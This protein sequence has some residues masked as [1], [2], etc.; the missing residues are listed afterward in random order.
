MVL[1]PASK[2]SQGEERSIFQKP[3]KHSHHCHHKWTYKDYPECPKWHQTALRLM[4]IVL[5]ILV[6]TVIGLI[7]RVSHQNMHSFSDNHSEQIFSNENGTKYCN[8]MNT[9]P[10]KQLN[11]ANSAANLCP[12]DWLH[13]K[14][15]CYKFFMNF[16][17]WIDSQ[18]SCSL[19]KSHLLV[20][21]DK[22]ELE[23]IQS[24]IQVGNHF[25]IGLNITYPQKTWTWVDGTPLNLQ[26]FQ[27]TGQIKENAC[28][29]IT[30]KGVFSEKCL[31][32][33]FWI[34]Q[35]VISSSKAGNL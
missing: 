34:C 2:M 9:S 21:Q 10:R 31:M 28:A 1:S 32:E 22:A 6:T 26:L 8:C 12:D 30:N 14:G 24:N 16:K 18:N 20:I 15:K 3:R 11:N 23:F 25:W 7:I 27:V 19:K 5:V 4:G 29:L 33:S 13:K 17:S 35:E